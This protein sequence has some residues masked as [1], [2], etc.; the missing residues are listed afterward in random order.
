MRRYALA[1]ALAYA[2][3][4]TGCAGND[5]DTDTPAPATTATAQVSETATPTTTLA[6]RATPRS[7]TP[8]V[9]TAEYWLREDREGYLTMVVDESYTDDQLEDA[10]L[11]VRRM[12]G[13]TSDGGWHVQI[14]CGDSQQS[15]GGARQANGKFALDGLGAARTGLGVGDYEFEPLPSRTSCDG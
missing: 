12:Y 2:L 3:T 8:T 7:T 6:P 15:E 9:E 1:G 5:A 4:L 13:N 14:N 10:F 11:E